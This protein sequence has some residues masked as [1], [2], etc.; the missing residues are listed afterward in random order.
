[1]LI[2][3]SALRQARSACSAVAK[4]PAARRRPLTSSYSAWYRVTPSDVTRG[5]TNP[6][7][8]LSH[9]R[10]T[11][12]RSCHWGVTEP[13]A[14]M[15]CRYP[16]RHDTK[17]SN[18]RSAWHDPSRTGT[19]LDRSPTLAVWGSGVRVPSAPPVFLGVCT[20]WVTFA[21]PFLPQFRA[22]SCFTAGAWS[23]V[24]A[25]GCSRDLIEGGAAKGRP[26]AAHVV[27]RQPQHPVE[28]YL[29]GP[30]PPIPGAGADVNPMPPPTGLVGGVAVV[31]L[32]GEHEGE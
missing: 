19:D 5:R 21:R 11:P 14:D 25:F 27:D 23:T 31:V 29:A 20:G 2:F 17:P 16:T 7:A 26:F 3:S 28:A 13:S 18:H 1:S 22:R 9:R 4:V 30:S 24:D 12:S 6:T 8:P 32:A 15:T 10:R